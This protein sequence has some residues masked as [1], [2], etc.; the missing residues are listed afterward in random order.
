MTATAFCSV[1]LNPP[2]VLVC[3]G[4]ASRFHAA[5]T[6]AGSWSV[7]LLS[8][9]QAWLARHF[10]HS[11]RDLLTQFDGVPHTPSPGSGA[12]LLTGSRGWLD[13]ET[14]GLHDGGD[15]T[16]AVGRVRHA[17]VGAAPGDP[18]TYHRAR[19]REG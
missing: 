3:V 1:S 9:D 11:G 16:I 15:H 14:Y 7:S 4:R 6:A 12:P 2:L 13:C 5:V 18:L 19:Y 8:G 17:A 10:S